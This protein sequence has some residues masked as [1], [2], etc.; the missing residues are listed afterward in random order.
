MI[1]ID[2]EY[3]YINERNELC[4]LKNCVIVD[5]GKVVLCVVYDQIK[6][7]RFREGSLVILRNVIK[8][9]DGVV[10]ISN[11]KVFFCV[12]VS[13]FEYIVN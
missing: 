9:F 4:I 8:K 3:F 12:E 1:D 2:L 10:V 11:I 7:L 13:V 5:E 6:F